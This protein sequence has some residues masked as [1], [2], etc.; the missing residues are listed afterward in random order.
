VK[1]IEAFIKAERLGQVMLALHEIE[2]LTGVTAAHAQGFGRGHD[3]GLSARRDVTDMTPIVRVEVFC[4]DELAA[5][6]VCEIENAAH[7]G[8]RGDGKIYTLPV[9]EAVRIGTGERGEDAV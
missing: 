6:V 3:T 8:L 5:T 9:E 2:G 1:K 7:T 4:R